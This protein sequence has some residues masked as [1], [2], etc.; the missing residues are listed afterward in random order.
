MPAGWLSEKIVNSI[1]EKAW[2]LQLLRKAFM[3][4]VGSVSMLPIGKLKKGGDPFFLYL[5][6]A[7]IDNAASFC[8]A[9]HNR[10]LPADLATMLGSFLDPA[11]TLVMYCA[12]VPPEALAYC[13]EKELVSLFKTGLTDAARISLDAGAT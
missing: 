11:G 2:A 3:D 7:S 13:P 9:V 1:A 8:A 5:M 4:T 12:H 10:S 6:F